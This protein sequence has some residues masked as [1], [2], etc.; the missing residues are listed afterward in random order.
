M[1]SVLVAMQG[2][3]VLFLKA[4]STPGKSSSSLSLVR[5]KVQ[6]IFFWFAGVLFHIAIFTRVP[7]FNNKPTSA[8]I[9]QSFDK[10]DWGRG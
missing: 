8:T 6:C 10:T 1:S 7:G 9:V 4:V 3:L 5:N 2:V